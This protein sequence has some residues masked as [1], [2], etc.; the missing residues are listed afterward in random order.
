MRTLLVAVSVAGVLLSGCTASVSPQRSTLPP[1]SPTVV[2]DQAQ[3]EPSPSLTCAPAIAAAVSMLAPGHAPIVR[4]E[5]HWGGLCPPGA[6]CVPPLGNEGIV[7]LDFAS[8]PAAFVYVN[9]GPGGAVVASSP[10]P[11]PSGY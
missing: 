7:I 11:Y 9:A 2:C 4:E 3:L 6:P 5:F 8:G 10:A 1:A